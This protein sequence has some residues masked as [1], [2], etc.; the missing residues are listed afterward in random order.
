MS[1]AKRDGPTVDRARRL[2]EQVK[3]TSLLLVLC[4][5]SLSAAALQA[6]PA[7]A[8]VPVEWIVIQATAL[9]GPAEGVKVELI[10]RGE[11]AAAGPVAV[12]VGIATW[13]GSMIRVSEALGG[14]HTVELSAGPLGHR[15]YLDRGEGGAVAI[16]S[17][18][19]SDS[20]PRGAKLTAV[21]FT[22]GL[23]F[24]PVEVRVTADRGRV[25]TSVASG[26]G[27]R[28]VVA[29]DQ[30]RGD[31]GAGADSWSASVMRESLHFDSP[32]LGAFAPCH[33]CLTSSRNPA[34]ARLEGMG[35]V[36]SEPPGFSGPRGRW[37]LSWIGV[38]RGRGRPIVALMA[39]VGD[40]WREF[41]HG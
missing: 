17:S 25:G 33:M 15:A 12:G 37:D 16:S 8:G 21:L 36:G 20:L 6:V 3:V 18:A 28:S 39:P 27:V 34:G 2:V 7:S 14:D 26:R 13:D 30:G 10:A 1:S 9:S 23:P 41:S 38:A 29:V 11:S 24:A 35:H 4:S 22:S 19:R 5:A 31:V 32:A 40:A